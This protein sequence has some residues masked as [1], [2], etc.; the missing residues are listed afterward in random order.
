MQALVYAVAV[1]AALALSVAAWRALRR[2]RPHASSPGFGDMRERDFEALV[3]AALRAQGY[4]PIGAT[5]GAPETITGEFMMRRERT[6]FLVTCRH[7]RI[8]R[9]DAD[10]IRSLQRAM[11]ARGASAG[12]VLTSG[13]FSR[14]AIAVA[15]GYGIRL[16]DGR[17]LPTLLASVK[18]P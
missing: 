12:V 11:A 17:A 16:V 15:A 8:G 7:F 1:C 18:T 4:E 6:S 13:R 3:A 14:E 2:H 5:Q 9:V 10:A